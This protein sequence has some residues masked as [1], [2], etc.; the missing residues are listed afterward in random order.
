MTW[1]DATLVGRIQDLVTLAMPVAGALLWERW[2]PAKQAVKR[3]FLCH[4]PV[5]DAWIDVSPP[6]RSGTHRT[7][8][9]HPDCQ[10]RA[11]LVLGPALRT[12]GHLEVRPRP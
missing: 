9:L 11:L 7:Y 3:C 8:H 12:W 10:A 1:L 6:T 4:L 2:R 5:A